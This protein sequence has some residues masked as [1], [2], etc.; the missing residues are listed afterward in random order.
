MLLKSYAKYRLQKW[1]ESQH[2]DDEYITKTD[3][4]ILRVQELLNN[5]SNS[6][7]VDL[8][9]DVLWR[10]N[11]SIAPWRN[12]QW[13]L[14]DLLQSVSF[15]LPTPFRSIETI[16]L[17]N[18]ITYKNTRKDHA[19][20]VRLFQ[21]SIDFGFELPPILIDQ[22]LIVLDGFHRLL[23]YKSAGAAK[24]KCIVCSKSDKQ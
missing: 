2:R 17:L 9:L 6:Y 21:H 16:L 20:R 11:Q 10:Q 3:G 14:M 15:G 22:N 23:A 18:Q 19:L 24:V 13:T 12:P 1:I 7:F 5:H 8:P 4:S